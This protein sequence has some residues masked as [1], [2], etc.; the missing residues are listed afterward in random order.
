[1]FLFCGYPLHFLAGHYNPSNITKLNR[2]K[3]KGRVIVW[4]K[5]SIFSMNN[6][7]IKTVESTNNS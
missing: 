1:M 5:I 3:T 7:F 6:M 2:K 4:V